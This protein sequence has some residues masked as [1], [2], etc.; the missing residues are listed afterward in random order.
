MSA[1]GFS[2]FFLFSDLHDLVDIS[3]TEKVSEDMTRPISHYFV[4][5]SHNTY[6]VGNQVN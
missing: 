6:L 4:S 3:M 5:T 2:R 1:E